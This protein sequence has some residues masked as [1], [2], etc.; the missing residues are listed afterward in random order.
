MRC[1]GCGHFWPTSSRCRSPAL[2]ALGVWQM[3]RRDWKRD[4]LDRIAVN[5]AAAPMPLDELLK[6]DPLRC[7]YGRVRVAGSFL[8]TRNSISPPAA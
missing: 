2:L 4:I 7:E 1:S 3:E 5:Q 8:T 6:G